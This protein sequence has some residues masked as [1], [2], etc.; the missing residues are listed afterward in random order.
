MI[1]PYCKQINYIDVLNINNLLT[2]QQLKYVTL[3][4]KHI[5][6]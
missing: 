6:E 5:Y 3:I 2:L 4:E 1:H